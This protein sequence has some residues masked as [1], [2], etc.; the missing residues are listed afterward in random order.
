M[1]G[2]IP[3]GI[4]EGILKAQEV[5]MSGENYGKAGQRVRLVKLDDKWSQLKPG[6]EGMITMV[7]SVGTRHVEWESGHRLGV[8]PGEDRWEVLEDAPE[9]A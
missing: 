8:I 9:R 2:P 7:D 5:A 1:R 3:D 4:I 6:T